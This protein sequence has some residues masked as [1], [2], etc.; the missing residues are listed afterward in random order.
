MRADVEDKAEAHKKAGHKVSDIKFSTKDNKPHA[1]Y[2]VTTSAGD[3]KNTSITVQLVS[4]RPWPN[5]NK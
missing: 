1:E 4:S 3:K 2:V 5:I